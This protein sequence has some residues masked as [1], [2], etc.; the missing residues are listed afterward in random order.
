MKIVAYY[1]VS[2]KR[3]AASGLGLDAQRESVESFARSKSAQ[4]VA[5]FTET[6]TG[7]NSARPQLA[8]AIAKAKALR[9]TL[10]IAKLDR[11]SRNVAFTSALME[12]KVKFVACDYPDANRLTI[13]ILAAIAEHEAYLVS[14]RTKA[15]LAVARK[16]VEEGGK[17]KKLGSKNRKW[18]IRA[19]EALANGDDW[20]QKGIDNGLEKAQTAA[21][22]S[23]A[24]ARR[25]CYDDLMPEIKALRLAGESYA[26]IA[27]ELNRQ[28]H[29]TTTGK[30]FSA[31][32]IYRLLA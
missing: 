24:V 27:N 13:H 29:T 16:P 23:R 3:Q 7:R 8:K 1:R 5:R 4:I 17:G 12:S 14:Q 2:T 26:A 32:T 19:A 21:A 15:A 22:A 9:A 10:C 30:Q 31:M 25:D 20:R 11:L 28:E 6:E 18:Q